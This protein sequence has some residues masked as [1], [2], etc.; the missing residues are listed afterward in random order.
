MDTLFKYLF[1]FKYIKWQGSFAKE[2]IQL[3]VKQTILNF[4]QHIV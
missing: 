1:F 2:C 3:I 4:V